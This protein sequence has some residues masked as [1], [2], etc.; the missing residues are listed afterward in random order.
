MQTKD[1]ARELGLSP[2][3]LRDWVK[4][5]ALETTK[6][7][8]GILHF[9]EN[10]VARARRVLELKNAGRTE[11][12]ILLE[13]LDGP[14]ASPPV[15]QSQP[16]APAIE[17]ALAAPLEKVLGRF[18]GFFMAA[19]EKSHAAGLAEA[20]VNVLI[21]EKAALSDKVQGLEFKIEDLQAELESTRLERDENAAE[22]VRTRL[23]IE[24]K[25]KTI[26]LF[27]KRIKESER[28]RE[29]VQT[30]LERLQEVSLEQA[31]TIK[32]LQAELE[33][34]KKPKPFWRLR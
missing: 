6:S 5:F 27:E 19:I 9:T 26:D 29:A 10:G 32:N 17:T 11:D 21:S 15:Y 2:Q 23:L 28:E 22:T 12:E 20:S 14:A 24:E 1:L 18:E 4:L 33:E 13:L 3:R 30:R 8:G 16:H 31:E 25:T 34:A 7:R